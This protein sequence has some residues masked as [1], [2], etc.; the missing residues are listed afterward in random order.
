[1]ENERRTD[2][3][4]GAGLEEHKLLDILAASQIRATD[5][6]ETPPQIIWIDNSTIATLGNFSASTG[7]AKSKKTFNVSALVAASLAGRQVLNYRAH[8]PEGK[9]RI[10]YV[11]TEQSRF[12]CHTVLERILRLAGLPTKTDNENLDFICLREYTPAVRIEV[13]DYALRQNKGYGL[14]IIDGIR[15]LMLDINS[16]GESVEVINKM[17]EW[18]SRYDLH[19]HCVLHL[20]K[21]DNN[22]RGHIGTEMS[23]KAETVLVI[24]KSNDN[25]SVSEVHALHIREKEFKPFA[26]TVDD[27]GLPVIA[28]HHSFNGDIKQKSRMSF[29]DLSLEQHREALAAAFGDKPIKGFENM[30]QALMDSYAAIGFKRGRSVMVK[31]LQYLTDNL[32]LIIK[33]DKLFYNDMTPAEVMLFDEE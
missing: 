15:D 16:T 17:M 1:M 25:P 20:N 7:K 13:I 21:G 29:M 23:N 2:Y 32:K 26:F 3:S 27:N 6:Y 33:R 19:I 18:S 5:T 10:L 24:S 31:L 30:L 4:I 14:V 11:D 28:E 9:R 22:V 8:L 12:H